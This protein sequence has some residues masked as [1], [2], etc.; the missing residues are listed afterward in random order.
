[1][2]NIERR[3]GIELI[4][5]FHDDLSIFNSL[6]KIILTDFILI[7]KLKRGS[8]TQTKLTKFNKPYSIPNRVDYIV[9]SILSVKHR[10][11]YSKSSFPFPIPHIVLAEDLNSNFPSLISHD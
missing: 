9:Y 8:N 6:T 11:R 1:M 5:F 3:T 4:V 2:E 7:S 10:V